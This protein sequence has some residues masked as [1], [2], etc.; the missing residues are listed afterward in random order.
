MSSILQHQKRVQEEKKELV[1]KQIK[2]EKRKNQYTLEFQF[3]SNIDMSMLKQIQQFSQVLPP[4]IPQ[5]IV[6][7]LNSNIQIPQLTC[8]DYQLGNLSIDP[9]SF[10]YKVIRYDKCK[11][12]HVFY[13]EPIE[14][15]YTPMTIIKEIFGKKNEQLA[16]IFNNL[17]NNK[18]NIEKYNIVNENE[19]EE[20]ERLITTAYSLYISKYKNGVITSIAR[21]MN[22]QY[23]KLIGINEAII[24]DYLS[25]TG[26][27]PWP[28][29]QNEN[30]QWDSDLLQLFSCDE[31]NNSITG[32]AI[33]YNGNLFPVILTQFNYY[34]YNETEQSYTQY[35]YYVYE[36]NLK[37]SNDNQI[38]QNYLNY[39][40]KRLDYLESIN[41]NS[42]K[43]CKYKFI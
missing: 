37:W 7:R 17:H 40:N 14:R 28:Y 2:K 4:S 20:F 13:F 18:L 29:K 10:N 34:L 25:S 27:L 12:T 16:K 24:Y 30:T 26:C 19:L 3:G 33:N 23:L 31:S 41:P 21:G 1:T 9:H 11:N 38:H 36:Y 6:F 39:F 8:R 15:Q 43:R 22:E 35:K 42:I 32:Q 5:N